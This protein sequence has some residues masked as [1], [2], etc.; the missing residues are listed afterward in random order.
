[1][2]RHLTTAVATSLVVVALT[3]CVPLDESAPSPSSSVSETPPLQPLEYEAMPSTIV[4]P[5]ELY[6]TTG[7][8]ERVA[9][10]SK[11]SPARQILDGTFTYGSEVPGTV[12]LLYAEKS[13]GGQQA[14]IPWTQQGN[15]IGYLVWCSTETRFRLTSSDGSTG[16]DLSDLGSAC[17]SSGSSG[18]SAG[19]SPG[20]ESIFLNFVPATDVSAE[21]IV[22]SYKGIEQH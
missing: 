8:A 14:I 21:V 4:P 3:A 9:R 20:V 11:D 17:E 10:L 19:I 15:Y 1:M 6:S 22:F 12:R 16:R 7:L 13:V 2:K 18:G 5:L